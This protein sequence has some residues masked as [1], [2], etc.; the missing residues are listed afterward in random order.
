MFC[1]CLNI[2]M[3][4]IILNRL[5][6]SI[7]LRICLVVR[8][9]FLCRCVVR[10]LK[11]EVMKMSKVCSYGLEVGFVKVWI[12]WLGMLFMCVFIGCLGFVL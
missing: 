8:I 7:V 11:V 2:I 9:L 12:K 3:K 10:L 1:I 6:F 5:L 4:M